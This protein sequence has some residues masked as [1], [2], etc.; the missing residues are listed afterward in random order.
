MKILVITEKRIIHKAKHRSSVR[1]RAF[2][3]K[4]STKCGI[5]VDSI[6]VINAWKTIT[7]ELCLNCKV[8]E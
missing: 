6:D 1:D 2:F 4:R 8:K 3:G 7:C 5:E